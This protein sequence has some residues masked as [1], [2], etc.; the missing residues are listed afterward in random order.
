M[1]VETLYYTSVELWDLRDL[2]EYGRPT[3][4]AGDWRSEL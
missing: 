3:L 1:Q 2:I 4:D